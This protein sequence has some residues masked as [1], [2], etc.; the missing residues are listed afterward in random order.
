MG[1]IGNEIGLGHQARDRW[2]RAN[3][4][5]DLGDEQR[6]ARKKLNGGEECRAGEDQEYGK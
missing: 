3:P 2:P 6:L 1:K 4:P 5:R